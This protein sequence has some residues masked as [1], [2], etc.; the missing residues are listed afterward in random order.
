MPMH[1]SGTC[2]AIETFLESVRA[3][4]LTVGK[5]GC[6]SASLIELYR[7]NGTREADGLILPDTVVRPTVSDMRL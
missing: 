3:Y 4:N 1:S 6:C 7:G 2:Y 5:P